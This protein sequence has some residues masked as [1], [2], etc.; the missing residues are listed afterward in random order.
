MLNTYKYAYY[1][2]NI[3][4]GIKYILNTI[5]NLLYSG[6][7]YVFAHPYIRNT[8]THTQTL[9]QQAMLKSERVAPKPIVEVLARTGWQGCRQIMGICSLNT[10]GSLS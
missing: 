8:H 1:I 6:L 10:Q 9:A 4:I 7:Q 3:H 5:L 2:L